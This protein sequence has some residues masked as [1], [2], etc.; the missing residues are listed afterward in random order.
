MTRTTPTSAAEEQAPK[1]GSQPLELSIVVP[2]LNEEA[3]VTAL[4]RD[5]ERQIMDHGIAGELIVIDDGST[6]RTLAVLR[7][8]AASRSWLRVL[9]HERPR[10]QS[11]AMGAGIAA[12]Q[13]TWIA[14]LDADGQNDPGDLALMLQRV[15]AGDV[16]FIQGD[17]SAAR[18][19]T[20]VRRVSSR[21][22]R[23]F[24]RA[25]LGDTIRDTGCSARVM[26]AGIAR[27]LPLQYKGMH[28]FMPVYAR[29]LG[30]VVVEQPV[31]HRSRT[32]GRSKY[33]MWNRGLPGL[34][35][36]LAVRWMLRRY[37]PIDAAEHGTTLREA[38]R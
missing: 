10:G 36:C 9:R 33:G 34:I 28:R 13:G 4:V 2:A 30:A 32:A 21:I 17:R 29:M 6:D 38:G 26:R 27:Q 11:A 23:T 37:R 3:N 7:E 1:A 8:L 20:W 18:R 24:R 31:R 35:D 12:A 14:M 19:D 5:V 25:L 22:G 15:R 16:D